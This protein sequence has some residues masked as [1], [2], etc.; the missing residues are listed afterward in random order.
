M[1]KKSRKR[2]R[3][4]IMKRKQLGIADGKDTKWQMKKNDKKK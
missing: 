2:V 4:D 3:I 1:T